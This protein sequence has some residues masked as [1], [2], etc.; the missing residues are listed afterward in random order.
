ML[1]KNIFIAALGMSAFMVSSQSMAKVDFIIGAGYD[2]GGETLVEAYYTNGDSTKVKTGEGL[3]IFGGVDYFL[4][5][6]LKLRG[7]IGYKFSS[8]SASNGDITF[9]RFPLD[10]LLLKGYGRHQF[11]VGATYHTGVEYEWDVNSYGFGSNGTVEFEDSLGFIVH[12][13]Y[14]V[15]L[16]ND[17]AFVIGARYTQIDYEVKD[18]DLSYDGSGFGLNL[19]F[20]F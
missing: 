18:T 15:P 14:R 6:E 9:D 7:T 4:Q 12:Y 3:S 5:D 11:G 17:N 20:T 16:K 19:G 10:L 8:A 1:K 13:E 2:F